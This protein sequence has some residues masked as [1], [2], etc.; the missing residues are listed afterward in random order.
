MG[1]GGASVDKRISKE[2]LRVIEPLTLE[3]SLEAIERIA[4]GNN[5]K[6]NS[7]EFQIKQVEY[8]AQRA[9]EQ[10]DQVDP[11]NRLVADQLEKRW[12]EKLILL[13]E[14]QEQIKKIKNEQTI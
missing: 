12:N 5:D 9:F 1:F 10:Y 11:R 2:I 14:L 7:L 6:I 8:E 4:E 13:G 3:A